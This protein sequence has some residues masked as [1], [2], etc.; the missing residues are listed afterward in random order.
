MS[1]F[2]A[3]HQGRARLRLVLGPGDRPGLVERRHRRGKPPL[4]QVA[5]RLALP[6][7]PLAGDLGDFRGAV[8][9]PQ[10]GEQPA[11]L[12]AGELPIVAG[13]DQLCPRLPGFGQQLAGH[14]GVEHRR[15]VHDDHGVP[16]PLRPPVLQREQRR[17]H[18]ARFGET[19]PP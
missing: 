5:R 18:R 10:F 3:V 19:R 13:Q 4:G 14:P 17:V 2:Q 8:P 9:L 1:R 7:R 11:A 16:V 15:L 12:D 6:V